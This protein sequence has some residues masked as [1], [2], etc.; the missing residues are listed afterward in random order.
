MFDFDYKTE[1]LNQIIHSIL[2]RIPSVLIEIIFEYVKDD[3]LFSNFYTDMLKIAMT[4]WDGFKIQKDA[5][6]QIHNA[7]IDKTLSFIK[8]EIKAY[9]SNKNELRH[10]L[11]VMKALQILFEFDSKRNF[12]IKESNFRHLNQ[13]TYFLVDFYYLIWSQT[14]NTKESIMNFLN[15]IK[16]HHFK[17]IK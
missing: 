11:E 2:T 5:T 3:Y 12:L 14:D 16:A 17:Q 8:H 1:N 15:A 6:K 7:L 10:N 13:C 4:G 9:N